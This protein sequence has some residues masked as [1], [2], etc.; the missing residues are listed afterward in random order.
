[1]ACCN[2]GV[3]TRDWPWRKSIRCINA[4]AVHQS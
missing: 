2:C 3:I 1:M 4:M